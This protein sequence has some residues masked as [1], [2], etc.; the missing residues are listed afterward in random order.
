MRISLAALFFA[1]SVF[2]NDENIVLCEL[3]IWDCHEPSET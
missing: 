3:E 1:S 2:A